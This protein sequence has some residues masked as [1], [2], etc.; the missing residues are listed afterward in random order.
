MPKTETEK[1]TYNSSKN[2]YF[3][4]VLFATPAQTHVDLVGIFSVKFCLSSTLRKQ[5]QEMQTFS[6]VCTAEKHASKFAHTSFVDSTWTTKNIGIYTKKIL[7]KKRVSIKP[8]WNG[9]WKEEKKL[10]HRFFG[11]SL[12]NNAHKWNEISFCAGKTIVEHE[13]R[14]LFHFI[15]GRHWRRTFPS[16]TSI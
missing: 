5:R 16:N 11:T 2:D 8:V 15:C 10:F 1:N 9:K 3:Y 12:Q 4:S 6:G 13:S 14:E 7:A